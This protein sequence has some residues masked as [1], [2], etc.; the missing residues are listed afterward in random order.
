MILLLLLLVITMIE[1]SGSIE[2]LECKSIFVYGTLRPDD[3]SGAPWTI[4]FKQDMVFKKCLFP[5]GILFY[6]SYPSVTIITKDNEQDLNKIYKDNQCRG[7]IGYCA[8][9][10][11]NEGFGEKLSSA[12][13]I[14]EYPSLY[15]RSLV[16]VYPIDEENNVIQGEDSI[17]CHIYHR[18][19]CNRDIVLSDG[20][21]LNRLKYGI[22]VDYQ[23]NYFN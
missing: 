20:D 22:N 11:K 5:N 1:N 13:A 21:W 7:I 3:N 10:N 23:C 19:N 4:E 9:F 18:Q 8:T 17:Q 6:D 14:E 16:T 12:D 2:T 15:N